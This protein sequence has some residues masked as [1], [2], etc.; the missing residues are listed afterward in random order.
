MI[1]INRDKFVKSD[2][3]IKQWNLKTELIK[4]EDQEYLNEYRIRQ[5]IEKEM[6]GRK[7]QDVVSMNQMLQKIDTKRLLNLKPIQK[8]RGIAVAISKF[9]LQFKRAR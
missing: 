9:L 5:E 2:L 3:D 7:L 8:F 4:K 6:G 1:K